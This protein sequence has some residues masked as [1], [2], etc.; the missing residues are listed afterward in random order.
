MKLEDKVTVISAEVR[1]E[2]KT[3]KKRS[4]LNFTKN[5]L[6]GKTMNMCNRNTLR[7]CSPKCVKK[8]FFSGIMNKN[9]NII[10]ID[11]IKPM[12]LKKNLSNS[13]KLD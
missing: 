9:K 3:M 8:V 4:K 5:K 7:V 2:V 10:N 12:I 1:I 11:V 6:I 13:S